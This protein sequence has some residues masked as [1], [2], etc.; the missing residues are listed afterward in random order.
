[1][2]VTLAAFRAFV[3]DLKGAPLRTIRDGKSFTVFPAKDCVRFVLENKTEK[4]LSPLEFQKCADI[5]NRTG[6]YVTRDYHGVTGLS[7]YILGVFRAMRGSFISN[8]PGVILKW[9][10][11][12]EDLRLYHLPFV[13]IEAVTR[14]DKQ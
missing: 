7:S 2:T 14:K 3:T 11:P 12:P 5:F 9:K 6:S 4:S 13:E 8:A 1:M 10:E